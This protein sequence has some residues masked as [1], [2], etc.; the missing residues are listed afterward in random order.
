VTKANLLQTS[1][2]KIVSAAAWIILKKNLSAET[3]LV[4]IANT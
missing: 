1:I 3:S 4:S 2:P